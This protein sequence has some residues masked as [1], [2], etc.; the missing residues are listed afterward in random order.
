MSPPEAS[1]G[2]GSLSRSRSR[3]GS[4]RRKSVGTRSKGNYAAVKV[5]QTSDDYATM[6]TASYR[7]MPVD[8]DGYR[9]IPVD[10]DEYVAMP[11]VEGEDGYGTMP[12]TSMRTSEYSGGTHEYTE[13]QR[14]RAVS[15]RTHGYA[16]GDLSELVRRWHSDKESRTVETN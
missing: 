12:T 7:S 15:P 16:T 9:S 6:P 4:R 3:S 5:E 11:A 10:S 8:G 2:S 13:V 14:V 1:A